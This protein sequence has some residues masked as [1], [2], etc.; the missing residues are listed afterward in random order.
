MSILGKSGKYITSHMKKIL[1]FLCCAMSVLF[2]HAEDIV[3]IPGDVTI[4]RGD[5]N[6]NVGM[7]LDLA[8]LAVKSNMSVTLT[9]VLTSQAG[10]RCVLPSITVAGRSRYYSLKRERANLS[11]EPYFYRYYKDMHPMRYTETTPFLPWMK[12]ATLSLESNVEGCCS[13]NLGMTATNIQKLHFE[14]IEFLPEFVFI[15]P[16]AEAVKTREIEGKAYVDFKVNQTVILPEFGHNP[17]EL[18]KIRE[19]I[20][21]IRNNDD[22]RI[23]SMSITGY[24]SPEGSFSNNVR[25][26][27]GRTEALATYVNNLYRFPIGFISTSWVP[28]DWE[29]VKK[30]LLDN[31]NFANRDQ[32]LAIVDFNMDPDAK[33]E[34]IKRE[35]P[36]SYKYML[37]NVYPP[38]RHSDYRVE[39]QV[40]SYTSVDEI[41]EVFRT[42]PGNLSLQELFVL[43]NSLPEGSPQYAAVFETAFKLYPDSDVA[44]LNAAVVKMKTGDYDGAATYLAQAGNL[45]E[46][47]YARGV[48]AAFNED[49]EE[50]KVLLK[51]AQAKGIVQAAQALQ[52]I[53]RMEKE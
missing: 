11:N 14:K 53:I 46:T 31:P 49:Y 7:T 8:S 35:F 6:L 40:K 29:G 1:F 44:A 25:L 15:T 37:E 27:K 9:P 16:M 52:N 3:V 32:I 33:N 41:A 5:N 43:G 17:Y 12:E 39:Y 45:P 38:L 20:D 2:C 4:E 26:A 23:T 24:A 51:E 36:G 47:I 22:T 13:K 18:A 30:F 28:E 10:E 42:R 21:A 19:S 34:M 50:A 48:L